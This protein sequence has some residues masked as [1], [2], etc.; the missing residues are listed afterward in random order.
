MS[1][2]YSLQIFKLGQELAGRSAVVAVAF[3]HRK[4]R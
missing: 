3:Q 2:V 1:N 4:A